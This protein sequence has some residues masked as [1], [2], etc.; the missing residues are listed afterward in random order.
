MNPLLLDL[1]AA[2]RPFLDPLP[3]HRQWLWLL[4]P[5]VVAIAVLYKALKLPTLDG[6]VVEV[7]KLS[8]YI[9]VVMAAAAAL[10]WVVVDLA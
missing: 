4:P 10:L 9:L 6:L 5:L 7:V 8:V 2:W 1:A 3:L